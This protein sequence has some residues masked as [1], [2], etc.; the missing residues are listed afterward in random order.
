MWTSLKTWQAMF[1]QKK[2]ILIISRPKFLLL[3]LYLPI[4][5]YAQLRYPITG[6]H[7]KQSAQSMAIWG[8]T[9]YLFNNTGYCRVL[10]LATGIVERSFKIGSYGKNMHVNSA[11]FGNEFVGKSFCPVI[12]LSETRAPYRCIVEQI[13]DTSSYVVQTICPQSEGAPRKVTTW[14]VDREKHALY[15]LARIY[16]R[17]QK[18]SDIIEITKYRLPML[19][20]GKNII[21]NEDD[22]LDSFRVNFRSALQGGNIRGGYMYIA[23]GFQTTSNNKYNSERAIQIIDLGLKKLIRKT[24]LTYITTNEPEGI[25]FYGRTAL[26]YTG[27]NGGI[28]EVDI[29][30]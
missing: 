5:S 12:Y 29:N 17:K 9:A 18:N 28:Y 1:K 4:F 16:Q 24:N 10:N 2:T 23:S 15:A 20:E 21:F 11:C 27:Q 6:T 19:S 13:S 7:E 14:I 25:D 26:L 22:I 30:E 8:D 3:I